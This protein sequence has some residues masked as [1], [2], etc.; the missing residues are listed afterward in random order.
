MVAGIGLQT[1]LLDHPGGHR[2]GRDARSADHGVDLFLGK[3][4]D[5]LGEE[6]AAHGVKDKGEQAERHD[7]QSLPLQKLFP[8][9]LEGD[10]DAQKQGDQIGQHLSGRLGQAVQHPAFPQQVAEHQKSDQGQRGRRDQ[11]GDDGD[12]NGEQ[13]LGELGDRAGLVGHFDGPLLFGGA[14]FDGDRLNDGDQSHVGVG[15]HQNGPKVVG[16]QLVGDQNG[17]RTVRRADD[18]RSRGVL[19]LK[20]AERG[21]NQGQED[22]ELGGRAEEKQ[23]GVGEQRPEVDHGADADEQQQRKNFGRLDAYIEQP[24]YD[25]V[26]P[27]HAG[28]R[29]I[30][31]NGT[32]AHGQ[33]QRGFHLLFDG[34]EDEQAADDP[35]DRLLPGDLGNVLPQKT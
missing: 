23:L 26:F 12:Q 13:D 33:Q 19:Q 16:L 31:Q 1:E 3:Q 7:E 2:E 14:E 10:G 15:R 17:G 34:Q 30:D 22:A 32:E 5:Q 11:A 24:L 25:A 27:K 21:Q 35:H 29:Q 4:I 28:F 20:P 18:G 6:D 9:H 8:L